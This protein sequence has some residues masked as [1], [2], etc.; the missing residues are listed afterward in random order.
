MAKYKRID[1]K[2]DL[3]KEERKKILLTDI[4]GLES[5]I[6][7]ALCQY[8]EIKTVGDLLNFY[9]KNFNYKFRKVPGVG[10]VS[11][12]HLHGFIKTCFPEEYEERN[13]KLY[14]SDEYKIVYTY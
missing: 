3:N 14:R 10:Q 12:N 2:K 1:L 9:I 7:Y 4:P 6:K 11:E 13:K 8:Y 5:R